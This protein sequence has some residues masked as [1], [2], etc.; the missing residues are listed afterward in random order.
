MIEVE[1]V[2][3]ER[4]AW[5]VAECSAVKALDGIGKRKRRCL[6]MTLHTNFELTL[7]PRE[8]WHTGVNVVLAHGPRIRRPTRTCETQH[9]GGEAERLQRRWEEHA[10]RLT[11]PNE[12]VYRAYR[13]S[14]VDMGGLR[15]YDLD[16][17][18]DAWVPAAG[19]PWD[20]RCRVPTPR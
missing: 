12:D 2:V 8:S 4:L 20:G 7:R 6:Q 1:Y 10:T 13:Q 5:A 16:C 17:Q 18:E 15:L 3:R 19:V 9:G 14:I 11:T